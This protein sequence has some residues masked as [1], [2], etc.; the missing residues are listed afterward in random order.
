MDSNILFNKQKVYEMHVI[1]PKWDMKYLILK[2]IIYKSVWRAI[3][4]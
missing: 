3:P 4:C 1:I 2:L